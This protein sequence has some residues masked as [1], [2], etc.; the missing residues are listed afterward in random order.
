VGFY[1]GLSFSSEPETKTVQREL[2]SVDHAEDYEEEDVECAVNEVENGAIAT[3]PSLQACQDLM[4]SVDLG[5]FERAPGKD[6]DKQMQT[7]LSRLYKAEADNDYDKQN[8][9]FSEMLSLNPKHIQVFVTKARFL[10]NDSDFEGAKE[11]YKE[12]TLE[13]PKNIQCHRGVANIRTSTPQEKKHHS[14]KC[15]ELEP[16]NDLCFYDLGNY[17]LGVGQYAKAVEAFEK[18]V[19]ARLNSSTG[20]QL[21]HHYWKYG[22]ALEMNNN[23]EKAYTIFEKA[24]ELNHPASCKRLDQFSDS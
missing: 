21:Q 13:H 2:S 14:E 8:E 17:Y 18:A 12:C 3:Q 4:S 19:Q 24:C 1:L 7:L 10:I 22:L 16:K 9:I 23:F 6:I 15:I 5:R 20:L 11:I